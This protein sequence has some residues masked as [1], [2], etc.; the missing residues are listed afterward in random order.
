MQDGVVV[1]THADVSGL[2]I[3]F[4]CKYDTKLADMIDEL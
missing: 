3:D 4:W 1:S 2:I